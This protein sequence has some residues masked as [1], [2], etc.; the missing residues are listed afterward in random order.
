MQPVDPAVQRIA[1]FLNSYDGGDC[2]LI[3]PLKIAE[4]DTRIEVY[5]GS[6]AP[7]T[8]LDGDFAHENGFRAGMSRYQVTEAQCAAV[9]F[10]RR[11]RNQNGTA[12]RLDIR[13]DTLAGG[14]I[15][16][17]TVGGF[18]GENLELLLVGADGRVEKLSSL[19]RPS[20]QTAQ[21]QLLVAIVSD[22]PIEAL[23]PAVLDKADRLFNVIFAETQQVSNMVNAAVK[24]FKLE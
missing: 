21:P 9:N 23:K 24:Y 5:G 20:G 17:G 8:A 3:I 16:S 22:L 6:R 10:V 12:R 4:G 2:F 15:L 11:L 13:T 19:L 1:S 14:P 7:L 18:G